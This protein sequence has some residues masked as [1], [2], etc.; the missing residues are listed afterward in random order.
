[1]EKIYSNIPTNYPLCLH[2][3]CPKAETCLRQLAFRRQAELGS[4][5]IW[6]G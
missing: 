4:V 2:T 1:M 3:D 6:W 5:E